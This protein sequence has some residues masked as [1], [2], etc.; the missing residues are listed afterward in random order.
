MAMNGKDLGDRIAEIL[1]DS[2]ATAD[3]KAQIKEIWEK[4]GAEIV[5]EVKKA[6]ITVAAGI[7]VSTTGSPAAQT[8]ATTSTGSGTVTA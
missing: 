5:A 6:Q 4:I 7:P 8:G 3:M 2:K 1:T